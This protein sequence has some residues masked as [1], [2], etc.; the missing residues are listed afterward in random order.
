MKIWPALILCVN[1]EAI[2]PMGG[3]MVVLDRV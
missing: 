3:Q 1:H 2:L